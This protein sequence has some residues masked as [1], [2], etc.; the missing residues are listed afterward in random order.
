MAELKTKY[1]A[2]LS[3]GVVIAA[4]DLYL[5][6]KDAKFAAIV[7]EQADLLCAKQYDRSKVQ[8]GF[9]WAGA[10]S[11]SRNFSAAAVWAAPLLK[12]T[13]LSGPEMVWCPP[14]VPGNVGMICTP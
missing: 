10:V 11:Q 6:S 1:N 8:G 9:T 12:I 2:I 13:Q 3:S 7:A 14:E 5:A 4:S